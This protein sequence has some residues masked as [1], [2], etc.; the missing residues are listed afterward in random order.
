MEAELTPEELL[1]KLRELEA[2]IDKLQHESMY[3]RAMVSLGEGAGVPMY[4]GPIQ[5]FTAFWYSYAINRLFGKIFIRFTDILISSFSWAF[6]SGFFGLFTQLIAGYT[7]KDQANIWFLICVLL[8]MFCLI[9]IS[10]L[11]T[12]HFHRNV[13]DNLIIPYTKRKF[14]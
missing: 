5:R 14:T 8:V 12:E 10:E 6:G 9:S 2:V 3:E 1:R 11:Y 7:N 4:E 13:P